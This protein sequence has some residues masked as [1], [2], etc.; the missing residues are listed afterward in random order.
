MKVRVIRV[1]RVSDCDTRITRNKFGFCKL[2]PEIP[3]QN[4]GLG[5]S[6]S[7][8]GILGSG[9]GLRVFCQTLPGG[10]L[11]GITIRGSAHSIGIEPICG[12]HNTYITSLFDFLTVNAIKVFT[13]FTIRCVHHLVR[14][15]SFSIFVPCYLFCGFLSHV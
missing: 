13:C 15:V 8:L 1:F 5:I 6:G 4:S 12:Q 14:I 3:E 11:I 2:L 10:R 9:L 7:G